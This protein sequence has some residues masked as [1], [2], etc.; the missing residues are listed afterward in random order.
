MLEAFHGAW[1]MTWENSPPSWVAAFSD[2]DGIWERFPFFLSDVRPQGFL[3]RA[4]CRQITRTH[5]LPDD[6]RLWQDDDTLSYLATTGYDLPGDLVIGDSSLRHALALELSAAPDTTFPAQDVAARYP[7]MAATAASEPPIG[8]S[9]GGEQPKFLARLQDDAG[10]VLPVIVKFSPPLDQTTGRRWADLLIMEYHALSVLAD[11]GLTQPGHRIIEAGNRI[12]LESPR[13]DRHPGG[14]R[15]GLVSLEA[16]HN[17]AV[18]STSRDWTELV[19]NLTNTGLTSTVTLKQTRRLQAFGE[20]IGNTDM[21][22]GN[23]SFLLTDQQPFAL[24]PAYDMLPMLWA[25]GAS[26]E[27]IPRSFTLLPPLPAS[28][29][30][31]REMLPFAL[32]FWEKAITD[33]RI[34]SE[35]RQ[36][37]QATSTT[38]QKTE[39]SF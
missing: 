17:A 8:S 19:G 15:S 26:G 3:G 29:E 33:P 35:M 34:S 32:R 13:F 27:I 31:W 39:R 38:I 11:A 28:A 36:A 6:P 10:E 7:G 1:C 25:P 23:L 18:G 2:R 22:P 24:S 30:S 37:A 5:L 21:H 14:G 16:L 20:L 4:I 12:F 9:A